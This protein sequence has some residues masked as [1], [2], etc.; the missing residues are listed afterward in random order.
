MSQDYYEVLGVDRNADARTIKKA[1]RKIALANHPD[2]NPDD[3]EAEARFRAASQAYS[4]LSDDEK[5]S[6]YDQYGEAGLSG[7]GPSMHN[8]NIED[9][10]GSFGDIFEGMF[11]G[12]GR[13]QQ[14]PRR[15][16]DLRIR[17]PVTWQQTIDGASRSLNIPRHDACGS[18]EGT[19][20]ASKAPPTL[21]GHCG[22]SGQVAARQGF[23]VM[24][25]PC[26]HCSGQGYV[27][28]DP[29]S[30]CAG[31]GKERTEATVKID[32]PAGVDNGMQM[33]LRG[34]GELGDPG[35][36]R[37][38]LL[39]VFQTQPPP[40]GW[41]RDRKDLHHLLPLELPDAVLGAQHTIEGPRGELKVTVPAGASEGQTI[42]LRG[43]GLDDVEGGRR[44]HVVL[45][46]GLSVPQKL[47]RQQRKAWEK[48]REQSRSSRH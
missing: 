2:Q 22:G 38:D 12:S 9:I 6:L 20:S 35:Q 46:V 1:Y 11:G 31:T 24:S 30:A 27:I 41:E 17:V 33:R 16:A 36:A 29:C 18:C 3:A 45:H 26:P 42:T 10:F 5:R 21:C 48:L 14:G 34:E 8:I 44:G 37:G 40:D 25:T 28:A 47:S 23:F 19:G 32:I 15:G 43:E 13:R 7:G 4:V 39:V